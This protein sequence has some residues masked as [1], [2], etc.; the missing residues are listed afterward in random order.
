MAVA[1]HAARATDRRA[2]RAQKPARDRP[3]HPLPRARPRLAR[4]HRGAVRSRDRGP[5]R[6]ARAAAAERRDPRRGVRAAPCRAG[7]RRRR[8]GG[9][10]RDAARRAPAAH[11][12][13]RI[14]GT[15]A[16]SYA[17]ALRSVDVLDHAAP[18]HGCSTPEPERGIVRRLPLV[19]L[20]R[21]RRRV[22]RSALETLRVATGGALVQ[23]ALGRKAIDAVD[24]GDIEVA[25]ASPTARCGCTSRRHDRGALRRRP[26]T[27]SKARPKRPRARAARSCSSASPRSALLD[28]KTTPRRRAHARRRVPRATDREHLRGRL[29]SRGRRGRASLEATALRRSAASSLIVLVP[30]TRRRAG[31]SRC[32]WRSRRSS[33]RRASSR[34]CFGRR[35]SIPRARARHRSRSSALLRS[36]F[37]RR[38]RAERREPAARLARERE[39]AARVAGELEA[40]RRIQMGMPAQR[41]SARSAASGA[42]TIFACIEPRARSA[43]TSTTSSG[44]PD[45][46]FF[47]IGRRLRQGAAAALFMAVSKVARKSAALRTGD[48]SA[49]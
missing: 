40:A 9:S 17:G 48:A 11:R 6:T 27:C 36:R 18:G 24:V 46:V 35:S 19:G 39:A 25:H 22:P 41:E 7:R 30:R 3:R 37:A 14:R 38:R 5:C 1:A 28:Y 23:R 4:A 16:P 20:C 29:L 44:G 21:R 10:S 33:W 26:P 32:C 34:F 43:A 45:R 47:V 42:S 31:H 2:S 13:A 12:S 15:S 8:G 49:S